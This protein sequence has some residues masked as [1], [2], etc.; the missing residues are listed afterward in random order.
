MPKGSSI[1]VLLLCAAF[2]L[3]M[4]KR[5][6]PL[7]VSFHIETDASEAPKFAFPR[8]V[9]GTTKVRYFKM[10][11]EFTD[12]QIEWFYPFPSNSSASNGV[13]FKLDKTGTQR[14]EN[15]SAQNQGRTL[16]TSIHPGFES[17]VVIDRVVS[18]GIIVVWDGVTPERLESLRK[19]LKEK[20][21]EAPRSDPAHPPS[22]LFPPIAALVTGIPTLT[23][24]SP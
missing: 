18:D 3:G 9:S 10:I 2:T 5:K 21:G 15:L 24:T 7:S 22:L 12:K 13:V 20:T 16:L 17:S 6:S 11:P 8:K 4:G 1:A 19:N 23:R 14:L